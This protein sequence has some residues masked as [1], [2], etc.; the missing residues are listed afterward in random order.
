MTVSRQ[1]IE[2]GWRLIEND[3]TDGT[4]GNISVRLDGSSLLITPSRRDYRVLTE[5]DLVRVEMRS[6]RAEGR[7]KPSS[8]WRLHVAVYQARPDVMAVVHH[9]ATWATAVAVARKSIPVLI[10]EAADIGEIPTAPYAA[11][12]SSELAEAA[13]REL[14][15]GRNAILLANHGALVVG[16]DLA[17]AMRRAVGVERLAKIYVGAEILGGAHGLDEAQVEESRRFFASYRGMTSGAPEFAHTAP[18][19]VGPV[20][21]RDLVTYSFRAGITLASLVNALILQKLQKPEHRDN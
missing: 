14:E 1:M 7:W 8:E 4:T 21:V 18:A 6:G 13:A 10:D 2:A 3:L 11:S 17:E 12:A 16:R 9:H 20:G 15:K 5:R 19:I